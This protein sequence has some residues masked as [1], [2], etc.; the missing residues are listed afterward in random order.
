[1]AYT[2]EP[3]HPMDEATMPAQLNREF[4][5]LFNNDQ[6]LKDYINGALPIKAFNMILDGA[7]SGDPNP[8]LP[9]IRLRP[10][11]ETP[12][13]SASAFSSYNI[14]T[15]FGTNGIIRDGVGL[16]RFQEPDG[17]GKLRDP[18]IGWNVFGLDD[19]SLSTA[20]G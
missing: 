18:G 5:A 16:Y 13:A 6:Q 12:A 8:T 2:P 19:H 17:L 20:K 3:T 15:D 9:N 14:D 10:G 11:Q 4:W 7:G 1:M